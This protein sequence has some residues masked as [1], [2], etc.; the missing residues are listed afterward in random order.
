MDP[1]HARKIDRTD[2][3]RT[4]EAMHELPYG[5]YVIGTASGARANAMIA[6]WVMQVSFSPRL[7][8]VAFERDSSSLARIRENGWFTVNL[9]AQEGNGMALARSFVQ[10]ADASKV[11]GR[12][13]E[14]AAQHH[15]KLAGI[16]YRVS[17]RAPGCPVLEDA[18][19]FLE[20]QMDQ[21][22]DVGDHVLVTGRVL[23]GD[24]QQSGEPLTSTFTGWTYSG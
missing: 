11:R 21:A 1:Q 15:D 23:F 6:D 13:P 7:V 18:L 5:I 9:L 20:C 2:E 22:L 10:P 8:A 3:D 19:A 17:E 4:K 14:A 24:V 12:S 16:D